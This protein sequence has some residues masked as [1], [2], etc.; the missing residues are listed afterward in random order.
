ME[1]EQ[2]LLKSRPTGMPTETNFE[3]R[4][5]PI[6]EPKQ[7]EVVIRTLYLSVDPYMRGRMSTAKS[8][9]APFEVNEVISGGI[10]GEVVQSKSDS[11]QVGDKVTGMLGWQKFNTVDASTVRK[12]DDSLA[13]L[14]AYLGILGTTGLTAYFG[15]L[16]IGQ[17]KAGETVVVSGAAG[18]V[19]MVVG[20]IAKIKGARVVGIAGSEEKIAYLKNELGFD[21]AVNYKTDHLRKSLI[22]ACPDGVDVYFDNVGGL[23]SDAVLSLLNDFARVPVCGAISAYNITSLKEDMGPRVQP[24]LIK[25]RALMK[26]FIVTDYAKQFREGAQDLAKWLSEGKLKY[27]ETIVDGFENVPQ[28]FLDLFKGKN[29][30]KQLVKVSD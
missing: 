24:M 2:I 18:A 30:G 7:G 5:V 14:S 19:G 9:V 28:A 22:E 8:Y 21:E 1:N 25:S 11:L 23:V 3:Y 20:Q 13:P 17:P 29:L 10:V 16:D 4:Q 12:V 15:L 26:G 6:K 27:E